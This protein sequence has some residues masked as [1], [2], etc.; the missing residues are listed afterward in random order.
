MQWN[1]LVLWLRVSS[2]FDS[3]S[4]WSFCFI[5]D[6]CGGEV[7]MCWIS[8]HFLRSY[9]F[10]FSVFCICAELLNSRQWLATVSVAA[11]RHSINIDWVFACIMFGHQYSIS[12]GN[13]NNV[14][15]FCRK[16]DYI[17]AQS[18]SNQ[19]SKKLFEDRS[20]GCAASFVHRAP[21][22]PT[23]VRQNQ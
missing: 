7:I 20:N 1:V 22:R 23:H 18:T 19:K 9:S 2:Q 6:A 4:V 8:S 12:W 15:F 21:D 5:W 13:N 17:N 3:V 11:V 10:R 14:F 16:L